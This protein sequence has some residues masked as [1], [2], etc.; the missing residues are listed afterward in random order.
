LPEW[1]VY[2]AEVGP[3]IT[4]NRRLDG[5]AVTT[6]GESGLATDYGPFRLEGVTMAVS[7]VMFGTGLFVICSERLGGLDLYVCYSEDALAKQDAE[8]LTDRA[9]AA[10]RSAAVMAAM[11][12]AAA[13]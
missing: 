6:T 3:A 4:H 10:L 13:V 12:Q 2:R 1:E 8:D 9:M 7:T 11:P 5:L